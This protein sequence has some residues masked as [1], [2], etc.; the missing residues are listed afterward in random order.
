MKLRAIFFVANFNV[1][2]DQDKSEKHGMSMGM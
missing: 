1:Y 2:E